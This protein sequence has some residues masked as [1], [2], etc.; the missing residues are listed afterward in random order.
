MNFSRFAGSNEDE[1]CQDVAA[2][3]DMEGKCG[4]KVDG[5]TVAHV[6]TQDGADGDDVDEYSVG[7]APE[8][9]DDVSVGTAEP[10]LEAQD[11]EKFE[12]VDCRFD[13]IGDTN[14]VLYYLGRRHVVSIHFCAGALVPFLKR[15]YSSSLYHSGCNTADQR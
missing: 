5:G 11:K 15:R 10:R 2:L 9:D 7:A 1:R 12:V 6:D 4:Q 14:G 3:E 8:D 13:K